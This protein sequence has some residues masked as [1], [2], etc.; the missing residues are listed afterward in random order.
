MQAA[1]N[2]GEAEQEIA[3]KHVTTLQKKERLLE[4]QLT[5]LEER[6]RNAEAAVHNAEAAARDA[7]TKKAVLE[8]DNE[9]RKDQLKIIDEAIHQRTKVFF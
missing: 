4:K 7:E 8:E 2:C 9:K 5:A 1:L 3:R 6:V